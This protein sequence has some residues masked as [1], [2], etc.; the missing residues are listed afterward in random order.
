[1]RP[2]L[3]IV[4]PVYNEAKKIKKAFARLERFFSRK[5]YEMEYI[6]IEDGGSDD[7]LKIL[8]AIKDSNPKVRLLV[9]E[10]NMGKG[11]STRRGILSAKGDYVLFIDVDMSTPLQAFSNFEK[12]LK[13]Y[14]IVIASR[15][16]RESKIK[17]RQPVDRRVLGRVFY[18]LVNWFFLKSIRDTNCGFKC[19]RRA[20]AK[21]IFSMQRL[22]GWGFDVELLYIA[23]K[24]GYTIKEVPVVWAH[25]GDSRVNTLT[26]PFFPLP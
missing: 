20:A 22:N 4:I 6:F 10:E 15:W 24:K 12:H 14:D 8:T 18:V 17:R 1:M 26:A 11:L 7:T 5:D 19:Y 3:S 25:Y 13:D 9:N 2:K 16:T 21:E 23:Q